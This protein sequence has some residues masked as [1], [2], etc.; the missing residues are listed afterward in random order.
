MQRSFVAAQI[1][2]LCWAL[3]APRI[4][5]AVPEI[6]ETVS[7]LL[8]LDYQ[9]LGGSELLSDADLGGFFE[10]LLA[11]L[12]DARVPFSVLREIMNCAC[13]VFAVVPSDTGGQNVRTLARQIVHT[14]DQ[15][16]ARPDA[17]GP[18][19]IYDVNAALRLLRAVGT[20]AIRVGLLTAEETF[21][22]AAL[23]IHFSESATNDVLLAE[24]LLDILD[25]ADH[26]LCLTVALEMMRAEQPV[27]S[28]LGHILVHRALGLA[29]G[30]VATGPPVAVGAPPPLFMSGRGALAF[31]ERY[32][33]SAPALHEPPSAALNVAA[34]LLVRQTLDLA[35][36]SPIRVLVPANAALFAAA[37]GPLHELFA[38]HMPHVFLNLIMAPLICL[39]WTPEEAF[40]HPQEMLPDSELG[41]PTPAARHLL[42]FGFDVAC[43]NAARFSCRALW[44]SAPR[45]ARKRLRATLLR[46]LRRW[47]LEPRT[48]TQ[49]TA[50]Y[51]RFVPVSA[52]YD[53]AVRFLCALATNPESRLGAS[54]VL[55]DAL[56][57]LDT[58]SELARRTTPTTSAA[59]EDPRELA[60]RLGLLWFSGRASA[61]CRKSDV[62]ARLGVDTAAFFE[63]LKDAGV[64]AEAPTEV[65]PS[66]VATLLA[67]APLTPTIRAEIVGRADAGELLAAIADICTRPVCGRSIEALHRTPLA[68]MRQF[69]RVV[70]LGGE[71]QR[72]ERMVM[73]LV[74][75]VMDN[76]RWPEPCAHPLVAEDVPGAFESDN[77][78]IAALRDALSREPFPSSD[79]CMYFLFALLFLQTEL[80]N[81]KADVQMTASEEDF[82]AF[83]SNV[84]REGITYADDSLGAV[85]RS[86][87]A[88]KLDSQCALGRLYGNACVSELLVFPRSADGARARLAAALRALVGGDDVEFPALPSP[89]MFPP[90]PSQF[91][92]ARAHEPTEG[93]SALLTLL[94]ELGYTPDAAHKDTS[95]VLNRA[96]ALVASAAVRVMHPN[97]PADIR[98]SAVALAQSAA[99]ANRAVGRAILRELLRRA[100]PA[101]TSPGA[102]APLIDGPAFQAAVGVMARLVE[103][104]W[105]SLGA[106]V[107]GAQSDP[108]V[109]GVYQLISLA[110]SE[111]LIALPCDSLISAAGRTRNTTEDA[112]QQKKKRRFA[113]LFGGA[114]VDERKPAEVRPPMAALTGCLCRLAPLEELVST[115][116]VHGEGNG[117]PEAPRG[118]QLSRLLTSLLRSDEFFATLRREV[119]AAIVTDAADV[120]PLEAARA[121]ACFAFEQRSD[122]SSALREDLTHFLQSRAPRSPPIA[123]RR[124]QDTRVRLVDRHEIATYLRLA[125]AAASLLDRDALP[126]KE[127]SDM[128]L[129]VGMAATAGTRS[130]TAEKPALLLDAARVPFSALAFRTAL[131]FLNAAPSAEFAGCV[132]TLTATDPELAADPLFAPALERALTTSPDD[133][134]LVR[135][136]LDSLHAAAQAFPLTAATVIFGAHPRYLETNLKRALALLRTADGGRPAEALPHHPALWPVLSSA[137]SEPFKPDLLDGLLTVCAQALSGRHFAATFLG[138]P[139]PFDCPF[140]VKSLS[141]RARSDA[142]PFQPDPQ[143]PQHTSFPL[144]G[145]PALACLVRVACRPADNLQL[146]ALIALKRLALNSGLLTQLPGLAARLAGLFLLQQVLLP[147][148]ASGATRGQ[149]LHEALSLVKHALFATVGDGSEPDA[150]PDH[151]AAVLVWQIFDVVLALEPPEAQRPLVAEQA[152][153]LVACVGRERILAMPAGAL[154]LGEVDA[155][156]GGERALVPGPE[157]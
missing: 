140:E 63:F 67:A 118:S 50:A 133:A 93:I 90:V 37:T 73:A 17:D 132:H 9:L 96:S 71:G 139:T 59:E 38:E 42:Q 47:L 24:T 126:D 56:F 136:L 142:W 55:S 99:G 137:P 111:R 5:R 150:S 83:L 69:V 53:V 102:S 113:F 61:Y 52:P 57:A 11:P 18:A 112:D 1:S 119:Q 108:L 46:W 129:E 124:P 152:R 106:D 48:A 70:A 26:L 125:L 121:P 39:S 100:S 77:T 123:R 20:R 27:H 135:A 82:R 141:Q 45:D 144:R 54:P 128:L 13:E 122:G 154:L 98:S 157:E 86:M 36:V 143:H 109:H 72:V 107:Q 10:T 40:A 115:C 12:G 2:G 49:L 147:L 94:A 155:F 78:T 85:F 81:T 103:R 88:H 44:T 145:L 97:Y 7:A 74:S 149:A 156:V 76:S 101:L 146:S 23:V 58:L 25:P 114:A 110:D 95:P 43:I 127:I 130:P 28:P 68:L 14:L 80:H 117:A 65:S 105:V 148:L 35:H 60:V 138:D 31:F 92:V 75:A 16:A 104:G 41:L 15:A 87:Q 19:S 153:N 64:T 62:V 131:S 66:H 6:T 91:A 120:P 30:S 4:V 8:R 151:T 3:G 89:E 134:P 29:G 79:S 22:V 33:I 32:A 21:A 51:E 84:E 116:P 34:E